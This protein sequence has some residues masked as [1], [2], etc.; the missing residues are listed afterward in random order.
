[1]L[2]RKAY[3]FSVA[4]DGSAVLVSTGDASARIELVDL[5]KREL[6]KTF[7]LPDKNAHVLEHAWTGDG[8]S[9][10]FLIRLGDGAKE[11]WSQELA[12]GAPRR[13]KKLSSPDQVHNFSLAPDGQRFAVVQ[14]G[15]HHDAVLIT[16]AAR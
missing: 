5:E 9:F 13:L 14:G 15:W 4:P 12:G 3:R 11:V 8:R 10:L 16:T 6:V 2:P 7:E 1:M